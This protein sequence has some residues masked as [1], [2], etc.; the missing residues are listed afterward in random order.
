MEFHIDV[1]GGS[2]LILEDISFDLYSD[3]AACLPTGVD[4]VE[5]S[6]FNPGLLDN[7]QLKDL[8]NGGSYNLDVSSTA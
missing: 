7:I 5:D 6:S 8:T 2:N 3:T 1:N 4:I